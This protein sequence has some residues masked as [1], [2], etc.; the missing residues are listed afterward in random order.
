MHSRWFARLFF[1]VVAAFAVAG[2]V[3]GTAC[4]RWGQPGAATPSLP[5]L[6]SLFVDAKTGSDATGN[7]SSPK[8]YKTLTKAVEVLTSSKSLSPSGVTITLASGDYNA[9]NGEKFPIVIPTAVT[10]MGMGYGTGP[11]SGPFVNGL[12]EDTTYENLVHAPP[13]S[14]YTTLDIA[15][16]AKVTINNLYVG[17]S[18]ISLPGSRATYAAIDNLATLTGMTSTFGAG[19]VSLLPNV[20]GVLVAGG[21]FTCS[22]CDLRGNDFAIGALSVPIVTTASPSASPGPVTPSITLMHSA[23]DSVLS[24][25][26][27][28]ILTDG[29]V[30]VTA[31]GQTFA[32]A[33]YA[34][35]DL[36]APVFPILIRGAIDF[37]GGVAKSTGGNVFI[38]ART[39]EI[40]I[41][42]RSVVVSALDDVWNPRTQG[43]N[44]NGQ[45]LRKR[46][47]AAGEFGRNVSIRHDAIGSVVMVGPAPVPTPTPS[48][49]PSTSPVP[50]PTSSPTS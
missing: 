8:P 38:G 26:V 29:S 33:E 18:K 4:T 2:V 13:R 5:P 48:I 24:A 32:R 50:T 30:N 6:S 14:A 35:S 40:F 16:A 31:D 9:A 3:T 10:L 43:S 19:I 41:T 23:G 42:R 45:Y 12:G 49:S 27:V 20:G 7:G 11:L 15:G 34:Y 25:K 47:F 39:T 44:R 36:L 21:T 37:G 22:S 1:V 46:T 17:S 28:D